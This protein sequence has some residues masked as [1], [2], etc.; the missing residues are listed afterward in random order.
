MAEQ[1]NEKPTLPLTGLVA[2][3]LAL[4][5][6]LV[7]SQVPLKTSR[8]IDKEAEKAGSAGMDRVQARLWQDPFEAVATH[9]QKEAVQARGEHAGGAHHAA[10]DVVASIER[11]ESISN[12]LVLPVFVD[13]SPYASGAESRLRDRYAL[14]SAL[15]A[16]GYQPESGESIRYFEWV[17]QGNRPLAVPVEKF[18]G[19]ST[20][21]DLKQPSVVLVLWLKEQDFSPKPLLL[22]STL[23]G[24]MH[25]AFNG[26]TV[27]YRVV[28][29]RSSGSLGAMVG[30]LQS[31]YGASRTTGQP[32][33][34]ATSASQNQWDRLKGIQFYSSWATAAD[35]VLLGEH[36]EADAAWGVEQWF[37]AGGMT[38]IRTIGTDALLAEQ[39]VAELTRRHIDLTMPRSEVGPCKE[40]PLESGSV[41]GRHSD[42]TCRLP[43]IALI[44]EW[45]T[46]YGRS[47]PRTFVAMTRSLAETG[48]DRATRGFDF[49]FKRLGT[50]R[51]PNW[52]HRYSYL[53]GL[54]GE[55]P[56]KNTDNDSGGAKGKGTLGDG[57]L[58]AAQSVAETPAGRSQLDY[59]RRL[60]ETL[61]REEA[62]P[63]G[64]FQAIGVLGSD[65]YDKLMILQALRSNFP[66]ALFFTTDLDARLTHPSQLQWTRNLVIAS[67]FGLELHPLIQTPIP[68]FR[69]SYQT[70][71][72][73][74]VLRAVGDIV[75]GPEPGEL[76]IPSTV[77]FP[78]TVPPRLYEVGRHGP[79]DISLDGPYQKGRRPEAL[80]NLHLPRPDL[81]PDTGDLRVPSL[82]MVVLFLSAIGLMMLCAV[83]INSELWTWAHSRRM[84]EV[85]IGLVLSMC[86][87][88]G[89]FWLAMG[90]RSAGEPF[91]ATDGVSVWPT[92]VLRLCAFL[93]C[94][95]FLIHSWRLLR[96]NELEL[97]RRFQF[98]HSQI[99]LSIPNGSPVGIHRWHAQPASDAEAALLW[100]EY[101][102]LGS[103]RER[104]VRIVPQSLCY[105]A[106]GALLM[107][108][109]GFPV[110]PCRGAVCFTINY[111]VLG[112]SILAMTLLMFYVVDATRLCRRLI[113]I[114]VG[115]TI[116]WPDPLLARE[117]AKWG[118]D[119]AYV[120]EWLMVKLI[121]KRT[122]VISAM[123][124]Y[125]FAVLFLMA[126]ARHSYF[127][128]W[129]FP[130][131]LVAVFGLSAAYA[132]GNGV[133]LRRSAE[134]AKRAAVAQLKSRLHDFSGQWIMKKDQ[135]V[136]IERMA[137]LI[138][139]YQDGAFLP[140]TRH[141]LFG[142]IALPAGG[143]GLVLLLEYLATI[144]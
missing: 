134:Q 126:V 117:A 144:F 122:A 12:A 94:L 47:L 70:A 114:M 77:T 30:E 53:A 46:L 101:V 14:V 106:F 29:P 1:K 28:G 74:S 118:V 52:V 76:Q 42:G 32:P 54:D 37:E 87:L 59:L 23:M 128:R 18:L 133:F 22:L 113:T 49:H 123:I 16:A 91:T 50:E 17:R 69:D 7:I 125:P 62:G 64:E 41:A 143:T 105:V 137:E 48:P 98:R 132:F 66:H 130:I 36:Q 58:R 68:P 140:V 131:G 73:Y 112:V 60:V 8:P 43:H 84:G 129:D 4:V 21:A 95:F 119:Q 136:Q 88:L 20:S 86:L 96:E 107:M 81:D 3:L 33:R 40:S 85:A 61:Q 13:G 55:L 102:F 89:L 38:L 80:P 120:Q 121:G 31:R 100:E 71:L 63:D 27:S 110:M 142:A 93:L 67:H 19:R 75:P 10:L 6:G 111:V 104:L 109:F 124:Y 83:L 39:L 97:S 57:G 138:E 11:S 9:R 141:P 15:G 103:W 82:R 56:P 127:D 26:H 139:Q 44:S 115:T 24:E 72:F 2:L 99:P 35:P 45:D 90:D 25:Q 34:P 5:S 65:V 135:R 108:L 92:A 78:K 79:V 51:Y 116:G